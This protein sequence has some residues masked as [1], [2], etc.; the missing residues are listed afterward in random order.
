MELTVFNITG[1]DTGKK[2][3]LNDNVFGIQPNDHAI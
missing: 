2:V 1:E 3:E